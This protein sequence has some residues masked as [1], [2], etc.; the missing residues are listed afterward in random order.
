MKEKLESLYWSFLGNK[1]TKQHLQA[2]A[3]FSSAVIA[4]RFG[5]KQ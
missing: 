5:G 2:H 3:R 1:N 4:K